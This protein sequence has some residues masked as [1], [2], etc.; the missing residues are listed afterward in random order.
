MTKAAFKVWRTDD[1]GG[2]FEDYSVDVVPGMV[3]L[4]A[5]HQI[6]ATQGAPTWRS[7]ELQ[8]GEV[9]ILLG[10]DQRQPRAD[11]H[12]AASTR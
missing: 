10:R 7:L 6:Q 4:D 9:R 1:G 12:D 3:V 8:G 2:H 5:I 11:V